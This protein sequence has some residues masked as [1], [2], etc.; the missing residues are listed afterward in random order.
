MVGNPQNVRVGDRFTSEGAEVVW[1]AEAVPGGNYRLKPV[2]G[3]GIFPM[4]PGG[5]QTMTLIRESDKAEFPGGTLPDRI[6]G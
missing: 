6:E 4:S 5:F 3:P 2:K 1:E